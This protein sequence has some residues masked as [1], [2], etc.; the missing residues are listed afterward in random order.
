MYKGMRNMNKNQIF[1]NKP[2]EI[3]FQ[4]VNYTFFTL[5]ALSCIFPFYYL[6]I[7]TISDNTL[8]QIGAIRFFPKGIHFD[9]YKALLNVSN[10]AN[11]VI[12]SIGRT[13][14]GTALMVVASAFT[15]YLVTKKQMWKR[16]FWYR[17]III[18]MYF[19]AGLIPW[20]LNMARLG[21]TNNFLAYIIPT[22]MAPFN[23]I[24]VKTYIESIPEELEESAY[25][26]GAGYLSI[27]IHIIWPV[28]K[29]IIATIAIFGAVAQWNSFIDSM[30][31][32]PDN[33]KLYSLQYQLY[34]YLKTNSNLKALMDSGGSISQA[35]I[36]AVLNLRT[37]KFTVAMITVLPI[38]L[39]YPL[40]QRH[41]ERGIMVGAVKG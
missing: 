34:I 36:Q 39:V 27:F 26:D 16:S 20:Y 5:F 21:L 31:L 7:N 10:L 41:F 32:M 18:T 4:L 12:V 6:F 15:G 3:I 40:M 33:P 17:L 25:M 11:S 19:N 29:P 24:L 1:R 8:T 23:I 30:I 9:N 37:V 14:I 35:Q 38:L 22:I 28:C 2:S 13:V